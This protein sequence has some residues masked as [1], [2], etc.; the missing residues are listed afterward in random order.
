MG[1]A[2]VLI[3]MVGL[4][5][6]AKNA[7]E[8]GDVQTPSP[9]L[10]SLSRTISVTGS[11]ELETMPDK[12]IIYLQVKTEGA[13]AKTVQ[14]QNAA[15]TKK[16]IKVLED[17]GLAKKDI[18]TSSYYLSPKNRYDFQ[19]KKQIDDGYLVNHALKVTV[20][21]IEEVGK[22]VDLAVEAETTQISYVQFALSEAKRKQLQQQ[23]FKEAGKQAKEKAGL[24]AEGV[25]VS[26]GKVLSIAEA[27]SFSEGYYG[28]A[29]AMAESASSTQINPQQLRVTAQVQ[30]VFEMG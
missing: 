26:V 7:F 23:L 2:V 13:D 28:R 16:V 11:A 9:Q 24:L 14:Q 15:A 12:A 29:V 4:V 27:G 10:T 6:Q 21:N 8:P 20:N 3:V 30:A 17:A 1:L 5:A 19:Q 18:E 25:G 22:I